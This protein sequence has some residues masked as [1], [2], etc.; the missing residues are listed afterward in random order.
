VSNRGRIIVQAYRFDPSTDSEPRFEIYEIP[1]AEPIS[2]MVLMRK[3]H[4]MDP[5]FACRTSMCFKG[6]C[7]SCLARVDGKDVLGCSTL[8]RPGDTVTLEPHP[9]FKLIR[10]VVVDFARPLSSQRESRE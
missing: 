4:E 1:S 5:T 9:G 3:I 2:V 6:A 8:V 7:G 10:D